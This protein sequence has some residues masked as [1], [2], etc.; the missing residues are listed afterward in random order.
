M[1][2]GDG[3]AIVEAGLCLG[4]GYLQ[5][6]G[7]NSNTSAN[8]F[9]KCLFKKKILPPPPVIDGDK[10]KSPQK[11][12]KD[13]QNVGLDEGSDSDTEHPQGVT[14]FEA[15]PPF[16][17]LYPHSDIVRALQEFGSS[18]VPLQLVGQMMNYAGNHMLHY[19]TSVLKRRVFFP[20]HKA[21]SVQL[22]ASGEVLTTCKRTDC[23]IKKNQTS[24]GFRISE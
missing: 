1:Q 17:E 19:I 9:I 23:V 10:A 22:L 6:F 16:K 21:V 13:K 15:I 3:I 20:M 24:G 12:L 14:T 18:I 2:T 5:Q 11:K 8:G 4:G 7:I